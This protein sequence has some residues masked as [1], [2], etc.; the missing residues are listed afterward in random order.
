MQRHEAEQCL[1]AIRTSYANVER[2]GYAQLQA[3][4]GRLY[5]G[6]GW[7]A[8]GYPSFYAC[9]QQEFPQSYQHI[10]RLKD[11]ALISEAVSPMGENGEKRQIPE[12]H[13]RELKALPDPDAQKRAYDL[14]ATKAQMEGRAAPVLEDVTEAVEQVQMEIEVSESPY[15]VVSHM[16]V[17][18][19]ITYG[20]ARDIQDALEA[21]QNV[22]VRSQIVQIIGQHGLSDADLIPELAGLFARKDADKS[23]VLAEVLAAGT[24][25]G[26]PLLEATVSDLREARRQAAAEYRDEKRPPRYWIEVGTSPEN[27]FH[28]LRG[29]MSAAELCELAAIIQRSIPNS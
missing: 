6:Q 27:V 16:A 25:A 29:N 13:A 1:N 4:I 24:L 12:R 3:D 2:A 11:A 28:I 10:Y 21:V 14:A 22:P 20:E 5:K 18:G 23:K 7:L 26:T 9:V 19:D 15:R 8:L 17:T